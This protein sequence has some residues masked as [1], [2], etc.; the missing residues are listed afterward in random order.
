MR[1]L[2]RRRKVNRSGLEVVEAA[3]ALP[4]LV[5]ATFMTIDICNV[6]HLKQVAN[7]VAFEAARAASKKS[8]TWESAREVGEEFA[9]ARGMQN[10]RVTV[11]PL[12][13]SWRHDRSQMFVG[14]TL[15]AYVDVP[16]Q[17]NVA[18]GPFFLFQNQNIRSQLVRVSAQ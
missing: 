4:V 18:G 1:T 13:S 15:R 3:I 11:E 5:I 14:H 16:V 2:R 9:R 12:N 6:I 8:A 7:T 10:F 17:G